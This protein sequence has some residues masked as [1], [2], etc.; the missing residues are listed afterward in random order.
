MV[1]TGMKNSWS[2][3]I[4]LVLCSVLG[5]FTAKKVSPTA[6][7]IYWLLDGEYNNG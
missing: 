7:K 3:L 2:L 4:A 6:M 5:V 1:K